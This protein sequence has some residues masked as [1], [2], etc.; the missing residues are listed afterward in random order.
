V[1]YPPRVRARARAK[2]KAI[3]ERK[4]AAARASWSLER[5]C[6]DL[7][8][9]LIRHPSQRKAFRASRRAAKTSTGIRY[10]LH[11]ALTR[12]G[13][14]SLFVALTRGYAKDL[15]WEPLKALVREYALTDERSIKEV[16][17]KIF[18]PNGSMIQLVGADKQKEILKIKGRQYALV[19]V[20]EFQIFP[21][22]GRA[23]LDE[24]IEPAVRNANGTILVLGTPPPSVVGPFVEI[25][26]LPGWEKFHWTG[27][28][29]PFYEKDAGCTFGEAKRKAMELRHVG[30]DDPTILREYDGQLV[31]DPGALA[32][33]IPE[34]ALYDE[35]PPVNGSTIGVD[36]GW[37][38]ATALGALDWDET[39]GTCYLAEEDVAVRQVESILATKL[40]A[41]A[42]RRPNLFKIAVDTAG[43]RISFE[44]IKA[45][46][47]RQGVS[48]PLEARKIMP[49]E[50]QYGMLN[51]AL[52]EGR[53]KVRKG[54][55]FYEDA[56]IVV[57]QDGIVGGKLQK[58][59]H[60]DII[61]AV[62]N[63]YLAALPLLP[64][65][66][67]PA[68]KEAEAAQ[69]KERAREER[70]RKVARRYAPPEVT[71]DDGTGE[72]DFSEQEEEA[73]A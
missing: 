30:A 35:L 44:S 57:W 34:H 28:E 33:R 39:V 42:D 70:R 4:T 17:L 29:N 43:N 6:F 37:H 20:D 11:T 52:A 40:Q 19:V 26:N 60:S 68:D 31:A 51:A 32:V 58:L 45:S 62:I 18:F 59:P 47:F 8:I 23:L 54:S 5:V 24:V 64:E 49:L 14:I 16:P 36:I 1:R 71:G 27:A 63:G 73:Y 48:L 12:P 38:D 61:P 21:S 65:V 41:M 9:A 69:A 66:V 2:L 25:L 50:A 46:L 15:A 56:L 67:A 13:T 22:F 10:L 3:R 72:E 55:R 53:L 7:Q